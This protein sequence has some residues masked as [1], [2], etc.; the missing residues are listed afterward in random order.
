MGSGLIPRIVE[1]YIRVAHDTFNA[2]CRL[3]TKQIAMIR[4]VVGLLA[5]W[6]GVQAAPTRR[7][8][9]SPVVQVKNGTYAGAT[10]TNY[11]QDLFLGIPYAQQPVGNLRLTVPQSLNETWD[12][13]RDAKAYSDSCVGY[14]VSH[15]L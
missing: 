15:S 6:A 7:D 10:N 11:S 2:V 5:L 13:E 4:T 14:G 8:T 9:S 1:I 12:G 3:P